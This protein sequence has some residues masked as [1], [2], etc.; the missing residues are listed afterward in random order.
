MGVAA[1]QLY[2][3]V[4]PC[5][6]ALV[7]LTVS[8]ALRQTHDDGGSVEFKTNPRENDL[9]QEKKEMWSL[10]LVSWSSKREVI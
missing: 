4:S 6:G 10:K 7:V 5:R 1:L 8:K 2:V 9:L 3:S